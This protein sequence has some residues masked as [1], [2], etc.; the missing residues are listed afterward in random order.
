MLFRSAYMVNREGIVTGHPDQSLVLDQSS[1]VQLS[2]GNGDAVERVTTGETG[3]AEFPIDGEKMLVA[4]SPIRGT[5]WSLVIQIPKS[6]Y[7]QFIGCTN[8]SLVILRLYKPLSRMKT[9]NFILHNN[10]FA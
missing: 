7:G 6:D 8:K 3:A 4:F 10:V 1:L 9:C 2:G 5:Q